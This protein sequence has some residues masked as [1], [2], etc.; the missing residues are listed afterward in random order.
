MQKSQRF[1]PSS[2]PARNWKCG[3]C[4]YIFQRSNH[5]KKIFRRHEQL[6]SYLKRFFL[7]VKRYRI[8]V[9]AFCIMQNHVHFV[10]EPLRRWGISFL[11]RDL[12]SYYSRSLHASLGLD[13]HSWKHHF[14]AKWI[15][16]SEYYRAVLWYVEANPVSA[17]LITDATTYFYSS[18]KA[19]ALGSDFMLE[20]R[21]HQI[22]IKLY[23]NRWRA[24]FSD[25]DWAAFLKSPQ[26]AADEA[27]IREVAETFKGN[28]KAKRA[29]LS[30]HRVKREVG[31]EGRKPSKAVRPARIQQNI[32]A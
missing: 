6:F 25:L 32:R 19:H 4:Y 26:G 2:R 15:D 18:A 28:S 14:G 8:R 29:K 9:H 10:L 12:Q 20:H 27:R 7:L 24:E 1:A 3:Q 30:G 11:M 21:G 31:S 16:S 5:K 22:Q 17:G 23:W 13:G